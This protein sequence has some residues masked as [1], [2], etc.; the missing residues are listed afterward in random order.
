[1]NSRQVV[2]AVCDPTGPLSGRIAIVGAAGFASA[3]FALHL[4]R[5]DLDPSWTVIS[6]YALGEWGWLMTTAF[7]MLAIGCASLAV[8]LST[9]IRSVVGRFGLALLVASAVGL[10]L[11]ALFPTDPITA[12]PADQTRAGQLHEVGALLGG[13]IPLAAVA[14]CWE[15]ARGPLPMVARWLWAATAAAWLGDLVFMA[16]MVTMV[17]AEGRLGPQVQ[18]GWPNRFMMTTYALWVVITAWQVMR[19]H[20]SRARQGL[21]Q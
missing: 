8:Q 11:A 7:L 6:A 12:A 9:R 17:P 5:P 20:P 3:L 18:I 1:M 2:T 19:L 15:L 13:L 14:V 16:A 10:G 21:I 4:L